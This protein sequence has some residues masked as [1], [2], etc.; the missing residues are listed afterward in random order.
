MS[1]VHVGTEFLGI[2]VTMKDLKGLDGSLSC[3]CKIKIGSWEFAL[4]FV[5]DENQILRDHMGLNKSFIGSYINSCVH[6]CKSSAS[7]I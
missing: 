4:S 6:A 7:V 2:R 3:L 1:W 5:R